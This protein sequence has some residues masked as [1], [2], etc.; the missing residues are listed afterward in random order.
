MRLIKLA[1]R[2]ATDRPRSL[3]AIAAGIILVAFVAT[4][5]GSTLST[6]TAS[7]RSY[8]RT[9]AGEFARLAD[10]AV[11]AEFVSELEGEYALS[12]AEHAQAVV[13]ADDQLVAAQLV[14][15]SLERELAFRGLTGLEE[16]RSHDLVILGSGAV[17]AFEGRVVRVTPLYGPPFFARVR[18]VVPTNL[19][20]P[21]LL[22]ERD[23]ATAA[24]ALELRVHGGARQVR[25]FP[26]QLLEAGFQPTGVAATARRLLRPLQARI[27]FLL[28]AL[29]LLAAV[30]LM[31]TQLLL[32]RN[33]RH[34]FRVLHSWGYPA[35]T[36]FLL[37]IMRGAMMGLIAGVVGGAIG[38]LTT[39]IL[40]AA[41][42]VAI[43][44]LP[45]EWLTY[46]QALPT[47]ARAIITP[48]VGWAVAASTITALLGAVAAWPA[49]AFTA[50]MV[51][52][53]SKPS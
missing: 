10:G 51:S 43:N 31:P 36:R 42:V 41:D 20:A 49:A 17:E 13:E 38:L 19:V 35:G 5:G 40:N 25:G 22:A 53:G 52:H 21:L 32:A 34:V 48:S 16:I 15:G 9:S 44:L 18:Q 23:P 37:V 3:L 7:T 24:G 12:L 33:Q 46:A 39:S 29:F 11:A 30:I 50:T 45:F 6:V 4:V 27:L 8:T 47:A 2:M 28:G 26:R 1:F 14:F